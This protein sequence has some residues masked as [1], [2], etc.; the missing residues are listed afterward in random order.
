MNHAPY[1]QYHR[2]V[3]LSP[4]TRL[5]PVR[6]PS[7]AYKRSQAA[8]QRETRQLFDALVIIGA[9]I[10]CAGLAGWGGF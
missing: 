10:L 5:R 1:V 3:S 2:E 7:A 6:K 4:Y 8:K 9:L